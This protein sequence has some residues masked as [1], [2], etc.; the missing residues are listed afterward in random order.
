MAITGLRNFFKVELIEYGYA[1]KDFVP[2]SAGGKV[3]I[4]IPKLM[5]NI[6]FT[7]KDSISI[8]N[9]F[10]NSKKCKPTIT[11]KINVTNYAMIT[12]D[13]NMSWHDKINANG[14]VPKGTKFH[15]EFINGDITDPH[16]K[17]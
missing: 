6:K 11:T 10:D 8:N 16:L 4:Y 9:L 15:V 12:V 17:P 7:G 13:K 1:A 2:V 14:I 3:P 5:G